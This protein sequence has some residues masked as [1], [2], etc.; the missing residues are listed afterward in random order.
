MATD[1][2]DLTDLEVNWATA[3]TLDSAQQSLISIILGCFVLIFSTV[4]G[5][6]ANLLALKYFMTKNNV[7]FYAL[8]IVVLSDIV[9]CQLSTFYGISLTYRRAPLLFENV[10]FCWGWNISWK[11][12][13]AFSSHLVAVQSVYRTIKIFYP[14][15]VLPKQILK[16]VLTLD[17]IIICILISLTTGM[18]FKPFYTR[19]FASCLE[20]SS[21]QS[22][23]V[24]R[25]ILIN[26][27][28]SILG[29]PNLIT[30][31]CCV[32]CLIELIKQNRV[33]VRRSRPMGLVRCRSHSIISILV[34][35]VT[36]LILNLVSL[37]VGL[38]IKNSFIG[39]AKIRAQNEI[40][41]WFLLYGNLI[42]REIIITINSI[43][44][45]LIFIWRIG[46]LR[47]NILLTVVQPTLAMCGQCYRLR[48]PRP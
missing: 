11:V 32:M 48:S 26:A 4:F 35:S 25:R 43:L 19:S 44:N 34:F 46:D 2:L 38:M 23:Y 42:F 9:I 17:F 47:A 40:T 24:S 15:R 28:V 13:V 6:M 21:R 3:A 29:P 37:N 18:L 22:T 12:T 27:V 1:Y 33:A 10:Y 41:T 16:V 7:F 30:L 36:G 5:T 31:A 20:I 39:E 45:P 8:K 14:F